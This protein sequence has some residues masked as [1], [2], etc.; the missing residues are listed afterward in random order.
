M[1]IR[2]YKENDKW[3]ADLPKFIEQG[4]TQ[5][6]L[7]MIEGADTLLTVLSE[8]DS[9]ITIE[10][11]TERFDGFEGK[12]FYIGD[13][14]LYP[15]GTYLAYPDNHSLW[16]CYVTKWLFNTYPQA[17]YYKMYQK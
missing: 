4:G 10:V 5:D 1:K 12:L 13:I 7:E 11:S 9:E 16:L 2:F 17:I 8:D 15:E 6:D 3:Y 14:N